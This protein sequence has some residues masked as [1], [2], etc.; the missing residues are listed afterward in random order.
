VR[1]RGDSAGYGF[2]KFIHNDLENILTDQIPSQ[3]YENVDRVRIADM[4]FSYKNAALLKLLRTRGTYIKNLDWDNLKKIDE[5]IQTCK[6]EKYQ[7][8]MTPVSVFITF[9]S[10]E[11]YNRALVIAEKDL[12]INWMGQKLRFDPAPEPTDII[13]EN[14]ELTNTDRIKRLIIT[15][16]VTLFLLA[17]SFTIIIMLKQKAMENNIKYGEADCREVAE[18]Y[19]ETNMKDYSLKEWF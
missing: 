2:K 19:T 3:G 14:R 13:W 10:E 8:F 12:P 1:Y 17:I 16:L 18:I 5:E 15:I 7:D 6:T 4:Q 9:E 11:G